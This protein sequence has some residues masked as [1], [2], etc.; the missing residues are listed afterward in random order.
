MR[1]G[2]LEKQSVGENCL[3]KATMTNRLSKKVVSS[4]ALD[5]RL[6]QTVSQTSTHT[7]TQTTRKHTPHAP[8]VS[9][10]AA[11]CPA[12]THRASRRFGGPPAPLEQHGSCMKAIAWRGLLLHAA[13]HYAADLRSQHIIVPL[14]DAGPEPDA[15]RTPDRCTAAELPPHA[16]PLKCRRSS[17]GD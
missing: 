12:A 17:S 6:S 9:R 4:I 13:H 16:R 10:R 3:G 1:R 11:V 2:L 5:Y 14:M 15:E 7:H 8:A